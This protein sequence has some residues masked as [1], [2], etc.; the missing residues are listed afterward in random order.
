MRT[1][2]AL[3]SA[4]TLVPVSLIVACSSPAVNRG[5]EEG[6][7]SG[8][9][10]DAST[11]P[12]LGGGGDDAGTKG[13]VG[14]VG[15][16]TTCADAAEAKSYLGCDF[17]PTVTYNPVDPIFDFA[18]VVSNPQSS[19]ATITVT[20]PNNFSKTLTVTAGATA[21]FYL[22]WVPAL[23]NSPQSGLL[24]PVVGGSVLARA[25]AYHLVS[26][27]PVVAY[28]FS[29]LEYQ[30]GATSGPPGKDWSSCVIPTNDFG[31]PV[32]DRCYSYSNDA[33]LLLPSTALTGNY[34]VYGP[35]GAPQT[36]R[37]NKGFFAITAIQAGT[38]VKI[39]LAAKAHVTAGTGVSEAAGGSS[40]Q[41]SLGAGDVAILQGANS[42]DDIAGSL[43]TGDKP[44]QVI[45]GIS[46]ANMPY[47]TPACDHIE[48][49][50]FPAETLGKHYYVVPPTGP[51][52]DV[53]GMLVRIHGN[54]NNTTLTY[55]PSAPP[56]CPTTINAGESVECGAFATPSGVVKSPFEVT[57]DHEF[58]VTTYQLGGRITDPQGA[59]VGLPEGDPSQSQAVAVEQFRTS[60]SFLSPNDYAKNYVDVVAPVGSSIQLDGATVTAAPKALTNGFELRRVTLGTGISG[61][62]HKISSDRPFGIQ[63]S[64]YGKNTSYQYPGGLNLGVIAQVPV[65]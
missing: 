43:I 21:K 17:W 30:E 36:G 13:P 38:V 33:S 7:G 8:T 28:Q 45:T 10:T 40:I 23:K 26:S 37:G 59:L 62:A 3:L 50:L 61:G 55:A 46:C 60:Y 56:G 11:G 63:V 27:L 4:A 20:G 49:S 29:P 14:P 47:D 35:A 1:R 53:P 51:L 16:P 24:F 54:V 6:P 65:Q 42:V 48:E 57:G 32:A 31:Q 52:A 5:T 58:A 39:K 12:V 9:P 2:L 41:L 18:A 44:I 25:S 19:D 34:R 15:D 64:G 22:P